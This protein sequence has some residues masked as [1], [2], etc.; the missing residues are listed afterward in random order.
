MVK[1]TSARRA[2]LFALYRSA[3]SRLRRRR[4][5]SFRP[6]QPDD[7]LSQVCQSAAADL[8]SICRACV[9][10][11]DPADADDLYVAVSHLERMSRRLRVVPGATEPAG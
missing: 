7:V 5:R 9:V 8:L 11:M 2:V 3:A 6:L 10:C 1:I 4:R